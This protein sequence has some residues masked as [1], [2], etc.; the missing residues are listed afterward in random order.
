MAI[1]PHVKVS[2]KDKPWKALR[3]HVI[4]MA[5]KKARVKVGV[6]GGEHGDGISMIEIA[7]I[8]EFGSP[9]ANIPERSFIRST[10]KRREADLEKVTARAASALFAGK[11]GLG[12][13]L[14]ILGAWG[15]AAIQGTIRQHLTEGPEPQELKPATIARKQSST[16]LLDTGQLIGAISF[17]VEGAEGWDG[18]EHE[19]IEGGHEGGEG[20]GHA[21]PGEE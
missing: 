11:I 12:Q 18:A 7:A 20:S 1:K 2:V 6:L 13:A 14:G 9:A 4:E 10:F 5:A 17:Q 3:K 19:K 15:V 21:E 8:H 16:P